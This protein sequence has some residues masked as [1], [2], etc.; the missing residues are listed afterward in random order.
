MNISLHSDCL[1]I[2]SLEGISTT[3]SDWGTKITGKYRNLVISQKNDRIS[4]S[5]SLQKFN[6]SENQSFTQTQDA[7]YQLCNTFSFEPSEAKLTRVDFQKTF[8]TT[9]E[10]KDYYPSLGNHSKYF[11]VNYKNSLYYTNTTRKLNFYDKAKE[12]KIPGNLFRYEMRYHRPEITLKRKLY[13]ADLLT[14]EVYQF[15]LTSWQ[16]DYKNIEKIRQ[17][18]PMQNLTTPTQFFEY[19]EAK[20]INDIGFESINKQL[21]IAQRQNHLTKQNAKRIRDKMATLQRSD[22]YQPNELVN[23]LDTKILRC[24]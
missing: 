3:I 14:E 2:P 11:R 8:N 16:A 5:G 15:L 9:F 1:L 7:I 18:I 6:R 10:P 21:R 19:L 12:Q 4:I 20:A 23:E 24:E 13:L 17:L 22:F